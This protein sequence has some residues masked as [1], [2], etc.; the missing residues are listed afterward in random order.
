ML[1]IL[2]LCIFMLFVMLPCPSTSIQDLGLSIKIVSPN[3]LTFSVFECFLVS[4]FFLLTHKCMI[5]LKTIFP[6]IVKEKTEHARVDH[7]S[8]YTI[9]VN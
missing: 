2:P 8:G 6:Q 1:M 9:N 5:I 7:E 4:F 3:I